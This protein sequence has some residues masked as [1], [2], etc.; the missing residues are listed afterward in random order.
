MCTYN[1]ESVRTLNNLLDID[2]TPYTSSDVSYLDVR[3][4]DIIVND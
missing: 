4:G 2:Q 1:M 3:Y